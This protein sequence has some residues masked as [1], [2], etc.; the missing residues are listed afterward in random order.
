MLIPN[1]V[2]E[3]LAFPL[4]VWG[5]TGSDLV[6]RPTILTEGFSSVP[7]GEYRDSILNQATTA[8]LKIIILSVIPL[9]DAL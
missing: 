4:R 2:V 9:S 5:I 8:S 6:R 1:V 7:P 3:W